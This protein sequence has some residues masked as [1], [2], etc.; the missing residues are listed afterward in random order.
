MLQGQAPNK[1]NQSPFPAL[2]PAPRVFLDAAATALLARM[3]SPQPMCYCPVQAYG[4]QR[5][6]SH[7]A[8]P[9]FLR[10]LRCCARFARF[11]HSSLGCMD[12]FGMPGATTSTWHSQATL[13]WQS[14]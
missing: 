13:L 4:L 10:T 5:R 6:M 9:A 12:M 8:D 2:I 1:R 3:H 7:W 11:R 14:C